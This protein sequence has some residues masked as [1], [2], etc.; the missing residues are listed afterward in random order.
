MQKLKWEKCIPEEPTTWKICLWVLNEVRKTQR[1]VV[2]DGQVFLT[3]IWKSGLKRNG[4]IST[5]LRKM[6]LLVVNE[7]R[8]TQRSVI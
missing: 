2:Q 3:T 8:K 4:N 5:K 1:N 6:G 7:V